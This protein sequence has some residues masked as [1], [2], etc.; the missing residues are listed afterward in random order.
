MPKASEPKTLVACA[1]TIDAPAVFAIV[2][3]ESIADKDLSI[4]F[5]H[6][7]SFLTPFL[8]EFSLIFTKIGEVLSKTLSINEQVKDMSKVLKK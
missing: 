1:P 6:L 8:G 4:L 5:L 7:Q 3:N 2:F